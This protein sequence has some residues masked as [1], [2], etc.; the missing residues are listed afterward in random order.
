MSPNG[1][2]SRIVCGRLRA[3]IF[4]NVE[5]DWVHVALDIR[6]QPKEILDLDGMADTDVAEEHRGGRIGLVNEHPGVAEKLTGIL[7]SKTRY[8]QLGQQHGYSHNRGE[9]A[10][11]QG[12]PGAGRIRLRIA[13]L[14]SYRGKR[15]SLERDG[16]TQR[17]HSRPIKP[18]RRPC[19]N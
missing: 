15:N 8:I 18:R 9:L 4:Q 3:T 12:A 16:R 11:G 1:R 7:E 10:V 5:H 13:S 2:C 19:R 14:G 6:F 17:V